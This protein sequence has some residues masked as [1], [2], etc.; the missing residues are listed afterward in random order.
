M[1]PNVS[2][3][4]GSPGVKNED[5]SRVWET[6]SSVAIGVIIV[7]IKEKRKSTLYSIF[8]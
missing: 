8:E 1:F 7:K 5:S 6:L 3:T 2:N 4:S